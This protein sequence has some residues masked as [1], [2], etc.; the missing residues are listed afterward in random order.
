MDREGSNPLS[1]LIKMTETVKSIPRVLAPQEAAQW[2]LPEMIP[3][4]PEDKILAIEAK[5][6]KRDLQNMC[7]EYIL[8]PRGDKESLVYKLLYI[9]ALDEE[10]ERTG[11]EIQPTQVPYLI[12]PPK[13][14]CCRI[15]GECAPA[16][17]L[18]EGKFLDRMQWLRDHYKKVHPGLWGK[19]VATPSV[20][21]MTYLFSKS[22]LVQKRLVF[23]V[24]FTSAF[25]A[26]RYGKQHL[27]GGFTVMNG[28][29]VKRLLGTG[30]IEEASTTE[31]QQTDGAKAS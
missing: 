17:L 27:Q 22:Y 15:C 9:G 8:D 2:G 30:Q 26:S 25:E 28:G 18:E 19:H 31:V 21:P 24:A 16:N 12:G 29:D 13:K 6:S 20:V 10:G 1:V 11:L 23:P 4:I 14:F 7:M 3:W 5:W